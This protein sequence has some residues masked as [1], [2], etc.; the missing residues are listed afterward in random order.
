[1][2][3]SENGRLICPR[4]GLQIK[5]EQISEA[6]PRVILTIFVGLATAKPLLDANRSDISICIGK[7][8]IDFLL[9]GEVVFRQCV[10]WLPG[11]LQ[12]KKGIHRREIPVIPSLSKEGFDAYLMVTAVEC[13]LELGAELFQVLNVQRMD[14]NVAHESEESLEV[15]SS[16][17]DGLG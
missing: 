8:Q 9:C 4:A 16:S 13:P 15:E 7:E 1:M 2:P 6:L 5:G 14:I 3:G 11:W 17:L 12:S 10:D